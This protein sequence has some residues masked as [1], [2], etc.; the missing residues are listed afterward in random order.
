MDG[1]SGR[2]DEAAVCPRLERAISRLVVATTRAAALSIGSSRVLRRL[3]HWHTAN[4]RDRGQFFLTE[5]K[6][7]GR[8]GFARAWGLQ[9][10]RRLH[11]TGRVACVLDDRDVYSPRAKA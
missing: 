6:V 10:S 1:R 11:A 8:K 7:P 3:G 4:Q 9:S 2:G 5:D